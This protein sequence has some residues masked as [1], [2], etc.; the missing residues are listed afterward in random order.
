VIDAGPS[1]Q[2]IEMT[3]AELAP[4]RA[5]HTALALLAAYVVVASAFAVGDFIGAPDSSGA[6]CPVEENCYCYFVLP[7]RSS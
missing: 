7:D 5:D 1:I 4:I 6:S 3:D 2:G